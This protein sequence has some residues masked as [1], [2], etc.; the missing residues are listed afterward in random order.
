MMDH[1]TFST[2]S[3]LTRKAQITVNVSEEAAFQFISSSEKLPIWLKKSGPIPG[4]DHVELLQEDYA[5][6]GA[7]RKV[8]F[9]GGDSLQEELRTYN[10]PGNYSYRV[11]N[12]AGF[13][14][15]LSNEAFGQLWFDSEGNGTR[16]TWE[17]AFT[18]RSFLTRAVLSLFL[19][20][21]YRPF[22]QKSLKH[23]KAYLE[24]VPE[25]SN[26]G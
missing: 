6:V 20:I 22:L 19:T 3:L 17:Y 13:L 14:G 2:L 26:D 7:K 9:V 4:A 23:A 12:I 25:R 1:N 11:T 15:K 24:S 10:P 18:Y 16:I 21:S 8:Y 5:K